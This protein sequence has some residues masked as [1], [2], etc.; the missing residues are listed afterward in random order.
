VSTE[1]NKAVVRRLMDALNDRVWPTG[2]LTAA[3]PFISPSY[4]YHDPAN[5]LTGREGFRRLVD[6]YRTAFPDTRF[7]I[8][9]QIAEGDRVLTRMTARGTHTG[10]LMGIPASGRPIE[11]SVLSLMRVVGGQVVEEWERFDT[12]HLLAQI[13]A[14]PAPGSAPPR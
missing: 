7:T 9:D 8:E 6:L 14:L 13:G 10:P 11:V 12:A 3:D 5:P 4:M 2:D 1:E